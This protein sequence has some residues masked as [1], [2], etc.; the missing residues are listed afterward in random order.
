[1]Q[2]ASIT[3]FRILITKHRTQRELGNRTLL[4]K[5]REG[6]PLLPLFLYDEK[7]MDRSTMKGLFRGPLLLKA[8]PA[9]SLKMT[10][11]IQSQAYR[12]IF[13]GPAHADGITAGKKK[14]GNAEKHNMKTVEPSTICYTVIQ[15]T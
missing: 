2:G 12:Y 7:A 1:M 4:L 15:V 11:D 3:V 9:H 8:G 5:D 14:K 6:Y 13:L 10:A